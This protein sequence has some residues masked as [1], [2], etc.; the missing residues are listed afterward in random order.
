M[1][2]ASPS[3]IDN[4]LVSAVLT[5]RGVNM[6]TLEFNRW[7]RYGKDRLYIADA[8]GTKLGH[9]DLATGEYVLDN[10]ADRLLIQ[11]AA[12]EWCSAHGVELPSEPATLPDS[13]ASPPPEAAD[14]PPQVVPP[15]KPVAKPTPQEPAPWVDL[16]ENKPGEGVRALAEREWAAAKDRSKVISFANRYLFDT[17][18]DERAWRTGADGEEY[19]GQRLNKLREKGWH[20]LHSVPVGKKNADIDHVVIGPGGVFTVNS[21]N[22]GGK[23]IWVAKYQMRVNGQPVPYLRNSRHEA[24]RAKKLLQA[25]LGFPVPVMGTVVVLTGTIVPEV[26]YRDKPDDVRVLDK[27]DVPR[28]FKK[29]P[30]VLSPEQVQQVFDVA[31]RSDTW[32]T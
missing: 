12:L 13:P 32:R 11:Q 17:K 18:T 22:H 31:R 6:T 1:S 7:K 9:V 4:A 24:A 25:K 21:K 29:R 16:A 30:R 14:P 20:V 3:L 10:S 26:T 5:L 8:L 23:R 28:W 15:A 19:V 27:W 2:V